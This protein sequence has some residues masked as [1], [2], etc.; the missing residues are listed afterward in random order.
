MLSVVYPHV[1][2]PIPSFAV[3][4]FDL[5]PAAATPTASASAGSPLNTDRVG[6]TSCATAPAT[7]HPLAVELAEA[8]LYR[9]PSAGAEPPLRAVAALR[10]RSDHRTLAFDA[11][12]IDRLRFHLV[13][14][15]ASSRRS[16]T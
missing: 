15:N 2:A 3:V 14:E 8:K 13:G 6:E 7:A 10:L 5:D 9:P 11:L 12:R 1:L 16:T 4:R